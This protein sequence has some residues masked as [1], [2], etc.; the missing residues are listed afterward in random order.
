MHVESPLRRS[1]PESVRGPRV[2]RIRAPAVERVELAGGTRRLVAVRGASGWQVDDRTASTG[3]AE[4]L[5]ALVETLAQLR[6]L[7]AFRPGDMA[8]LGLD[9]P[10]ATILVQTGHRDRLLRLGA[11]SASGGA[12]YVERDGH[13]R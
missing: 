4:A 10:A 1:G 9:P 7:D 13:P 8:T 12:L 5:D 3:E 2:L 6:A 11:P